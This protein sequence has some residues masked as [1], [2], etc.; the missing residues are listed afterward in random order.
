M[1]DTS[2]I[3]HGKNFKGTA[4]IY[5]VT[6]DDQTI[7]ECDFFIN[8]L[9]ETWPHE[10]RSLRENRREKGQRVKQLPENRLHHEML[11]IFGPEQSAAEAI[12]S[13]KRLQKEL[14]TNGLLIGR[15]KNSDYVIESVL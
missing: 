7:L 3:F 12:A 2:R 10:I 8:S 4:M 5:A 6:P 15:D 14:E 9:S 11:V 13:L 1:D